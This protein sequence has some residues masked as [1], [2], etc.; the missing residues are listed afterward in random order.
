MVRELKGMKLVPWL[1]AEAEQVGALQEE[2]ALLREEQREAA[3]VDLLLVRFRFGEVRVVGEEAGERR[4]EVVLEVETRVAGG[5]AAGLVFGEAVGL[6]VQALALFHALHAGE[7][8][9]ARQLEH[10]G[11]QGHAGPVQ[12]QQVAGHVAGHVEAPA[13]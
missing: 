1:I 13:R 7:R 10:G 8:A 11:I 5:A 12:G 9:F 2:L 4:V 6:E 3:G